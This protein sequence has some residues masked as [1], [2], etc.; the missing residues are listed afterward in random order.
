MC[1]NNEKTGPSGPIE[2]EPGEE[3]GVY[4]DRSEKVRTELPET[5]RSQMKEL[6][7]GEYGA[8]LSSFEETPATGLRLNTLRRGGKEALKRLGLPLRPVPWCPDGFYYEGEQRLARHPYYYAGLYYLQEP[9]AMLPAALLPVEPGDR[10]LDLCAAPGGKSTELGA[11]LKGR[12]LLFANDISS[13]R[14]KAL[15]KNLEMFGIA[16]A[17]VSSESP[18]KLARVYPEYFDRIL[19]DA[20]CSGEGMFRRDPDM[21][22][23]WLARG[24]RYYAP[25]QREILGYAARMLRPGGYLLY[26][27]CTFSPLENEENVKWLLEEQNDLELVPVRVRTDADKT[28]GTERRLGGSDREADGSSGTGDQADGEREPECSSRSG[29]TDSALLP[30]CVRLFPHRVRGEGH[31]AALLRKKERPGS[32]TQARLPFRSD[33]R[34]GRPSLPNEAAEFLG[35]TG[36]SWEP[37]RFMVLDEA[38][39]YLPEDFVPAPSVRF[40]RTGLWAGTMKNGRFEPSQALAMVLDAQSYPNSVSFSRE[41]ERVIRYL[42]GETVF[43]EEDETGS[44]GWRLVCADGYAL[45]FA[46]GGGQVLKNKYYP[47]WRW[48]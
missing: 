43:L 14:A 2:D 9:S 3:T 13:S 26:S 18:E 5:F 22:K 8:Y 1:Y 41:D 25:V 40:L 47:G 11:R 27:T 24:P 7:G 34:R 16:N 21:V 32:G 44:D 12:G 36:L 19:V 20:P 35:R 31:F 6:L 45:G 4:A 46:R 10:V 33:R 48:M 39:Y 15:L 23:D 38:V 30:G 42:K 37:E 17:C 28:V 29:I